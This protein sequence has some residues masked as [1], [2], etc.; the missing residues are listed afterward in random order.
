MVTALV[1]STAVDLY[2]AGLVINFGR[3]SGNFGLARNFTAEVA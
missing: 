1:T 3:F 2:K